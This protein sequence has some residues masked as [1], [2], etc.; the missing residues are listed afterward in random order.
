MVDPMIFC[1]NITHKGMVFE[2]N[3]ILLMRIR[4]L[5]SCLGL[6]MV[7]N[8]LFLM[9]RYL[10]LGHLKLKFRHFSKLMQISISWYNCVTLGKS[11]IMK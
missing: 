8:T 2:M 3:I 1:K 4:R 11:P 6:K 5:K 7:E 9:E 10:H